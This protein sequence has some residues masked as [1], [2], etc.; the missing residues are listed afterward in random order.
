MTAYFLK[1]ASRFDALQLR[2]RWLVV[3]AVLGGIVLIGHGLFVAPAQTRARLAEQSL[4]EQQAQ[5]AALNAQIQAL[6]APGQDPNV[7]ASAELSS[8]K[9][10]L[11]KQAERLA[12]MENSLVPP[13]Q[14]ASLLEAVI[15]G[16]SGLRLVSLKTLPVASALEKPAKD[17]GAAAQAVPAP[18]APGAAAPA[19][20]ADGLFKHGVEIKLEGSY[21]E[22][23]A[24]LERLELAKPKLLWSSVSL[25]A[26]DHPR[27]V[28]TLTVYSLSLERA[29][30]IV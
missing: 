4:A 3:I 28:L 30:L 23:T 21:Q 10:Q 13:H 5:L 19:K 26:E 8:L 15:G 14:M 27:L 16:Q 7:A 9:S 11:A 18:V 22:L 1:L 29:W 6:Q 25:S 12:V 2:E 17:S 24:Y 20:V